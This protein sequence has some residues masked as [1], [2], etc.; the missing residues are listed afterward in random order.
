M[1]RCQ[2]VQEPCQTKCFQS[3][4]PVL[5]CTKPL[6]TL[7]QSGH[8][9]S[10]APDAKQPYSCAAKL[11]AAVSSAPE[12]IRPGFSQ[13]GANKTSGPFVFP[14]KTRT[15][16]KHA[17]KSI[18]KHRQRSSVRSLP[19]SSLTN[20]RMRRRVQLRRYSAS[21]V[22]IAE[23]CVHKKNLSKCFNGKLPICPCQRKPIMGPKCAKRWGHFKCIALFPNGMVRSA[24]R[25]RPVNSKVRSSMGT[26]SWL[27]A[28]QRLRGASS[29]CRAK[30]SQ[31]PRNLSHELGKRAKTLVFHSS[32]QMRS[33]EW[34]AE[35]AT[36]SRLTLIARARRRDPRTC[37]CF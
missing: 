24:W 4:A 37:Q 30:L 23:P 3:S 31:C 17:S 9:R 15:P 26:Q 13:K 7:L 14:F 16:K 5:P 18:Q 12:Q 22:S 35:A 2:L 21:R 8:G 19:A 36:P 25:L 27:R 1:C 11:P 28:S 29:S 32:D 6:P 33:N 10:T 34:L 20:A